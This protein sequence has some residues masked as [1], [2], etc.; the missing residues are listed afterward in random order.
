MHVIC[1]KIL[2][3]SACSASLVG[4]R[5]FFPIWLP[6]YYRYGYLTAVLLEIHGGKVACAPKTINEIILP[7]CAFNDLVSVG[8]GGDEQLSSAYLIAAICVA[9]LSG[10][11]QT[12][13][14]ALAGDQV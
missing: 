3:A 9:L 11:Q 10:I 8:Y 6:F 4:H 7:R 13:V 12:V 14:R 5:W 1:M 2:I